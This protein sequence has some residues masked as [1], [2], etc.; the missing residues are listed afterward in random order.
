MYLFFFFFRLLGADNPSAQQ[1][2]LKYLNDSFASNVARDLEKTC[3]PF[4]DKL[5]KVIKKFFWEII[6]KLYIA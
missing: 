6:K 3:L 4:M 1:E 5:Y 2:F